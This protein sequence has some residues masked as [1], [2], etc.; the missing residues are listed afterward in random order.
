MSTC[1]AQEHEREVTIITVAM[2]G[3]NDFIM[4]GPTS[5]VRGGEPAAGEPY[6]RPA[7]WA[8]SSH[9]FDFCLDVFEN[10][11]SNIDAI[12]F[13]EVVG[14]KRLS[15]LVTCGPSNIPDDIH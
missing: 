12:F 8:E 4:K 13:F 11:T 14:N 1:L 3:D 5:A 9:F 7:G 15:Q 2:L 6:P 10:M